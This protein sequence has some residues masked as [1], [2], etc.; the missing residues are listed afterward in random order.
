MSILRTTPKL[1]KIIGCPNASLRLSKWLK[2]LATDNDR[3]LS[4]K[5]LEI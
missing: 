3:D 4:T 1:I 2:F 5:K